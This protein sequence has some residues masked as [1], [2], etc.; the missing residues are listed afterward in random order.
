MQQ[1]VMLLLLWQRLTVTCLSYQYWQWL[2]QQTKLECSANSSW[3][4]SILAVPLQLFVD[5]GTYLQCVCSFVETAI[6]T[7]HVFTTWSGQLSLFAMWLQLCPQHLFL[8]AM[9]LRLCL[10]S[11]QY[12]QRLSQSHLDGC[13]WLQFVCSHVK[14]LNLD[15][16]CHCVLTAINICNVDANVSWQ[17]SVSAI[18]LKMC[19]GSCQ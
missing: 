4:L 19:L 1:S 3:Q 2:C 18:S 16:I 7:R 6:N 15:F 17:L 5:S 14:L 8:L 13:Y 11:W 10:D 9:C 12:E